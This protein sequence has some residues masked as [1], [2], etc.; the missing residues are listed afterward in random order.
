M[1]LNRLIKKA[2]LSAGLSQLDISRALGYM[3]A[4]FISNIEREIAAVPTKIIKPIAKMT[5]VPVSRFERA[6]F[7]DVR[8]RAAAKLK[9]A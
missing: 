2:R 4:Q 5:G 9:R 7:A 3:S 1:K 8:S 6:H